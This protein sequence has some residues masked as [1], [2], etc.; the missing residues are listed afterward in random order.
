MSA[1]NTVE[2]VIADAR[3][4]LLDQ[5]RP[6]RYTDDELLVALN[7]A[8][9]EA[10]RVRADLFVTRY[11]NSVPTYLAIT[12]E[13]FCIEAQFRLAFVYGV[14]AHALARDDED[15]QDVRANSFLAKFT[16]VLLGQALPPVTGGTPGPKGQQGK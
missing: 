2:S 5:R 16:A 13:P 11:G 8:L 1:L 4:L 12:S 10:R 3:V 14:V 6:Y 15:V 7:T 9:L